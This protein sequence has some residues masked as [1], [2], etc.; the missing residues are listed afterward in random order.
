MLAITSMYNEVK[1]L[2]LCCS[3]SVSFNFSVFQERELGL[4]F[5]ISFNKCFIDGIT[6]SRFIYHQLYAMFHLDSYSLITRYVKRADDIVDR[7]DAIM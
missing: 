7:R 2:W 1:Y 5:I 6:F 3:I 4:G